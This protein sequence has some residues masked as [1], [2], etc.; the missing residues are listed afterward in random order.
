MFFVFL[1][2][3]AASGRGASHK[4]APRPVGAPRTLSK[5][6]GALQ[7]RPRV[8]RVSPQFPLNDRIPSLCAAW[9]PGS[10][11]RWCPQAVLAVDEKSGKLATPPTDRARDG[12]AALP[13]S[14]AAHS[15]GPASMDPES[16]RRRDA[17]LEVIDNTTQGPSPRNDALGV[18]LLG[19][20]CCQTNEEMDG[21]GRGFAV[22]ATPLL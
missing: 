16:P 7:N 3:R 18:N 10:T 12:C 2:G 11:P 4:R 17:D 5:R 1:V 6:P 15:P 21:S 13:S 22:E 19:E 20:A 8:A 9:L 14:E